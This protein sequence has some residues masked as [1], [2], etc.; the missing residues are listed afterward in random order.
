MDSDISN[1]KD[2]EV[3]D[4]IIKL[5]EGLASFWGKSEGWAPIEAAQLLTKSRLDWQASLSRLLKIFLD[6]EISKESGALILAWSALGSLTEGTMKLYLSVWY[7]NYK[8]E[9]LMND[10][11]EIKK[12]NGDL[13]DPDRLGLEELRIYFSKRIYNSYTRKI[14]KTEGKTDWIDWIEFVKNKRNAIHSFQNREIAD[15]NVFFQSVRLYLQ[16]LRNLSND[17]PYP[18]V[19][20]GSYKPKE[21]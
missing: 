16:F 12:K 1:F 6:S 10:I 3:L 15:F 21:V 20:F 7:E 11:K 9:S 4:R 2:I 19:E 5:N 13:I 17:F 14:W 8:Y 18:E